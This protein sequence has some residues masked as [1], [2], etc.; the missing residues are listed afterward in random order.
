MFRNRPSI[1]LDIHL[2]FN[3]FDQVCEHL[4]SRGYH[5]AFEV[6]P[7]MQ[8][9]CRALQQAEEARAKAQPLVLAQVDAE[10]DAPEAEAPHSILQWFKWSGTRR[11]MKKF[12]SHR[13]HLDEELGVDHIFIKQEDAPPAPS[14]TS[15]TQLFV[16]DSHVIPSSLPISSWAPS[17]R[18]SDHRP[19]AASVV[20]ATTK[21][22]AVESAPDSRVAKL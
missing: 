20:L 4:R 17:F 9:D 14:S 16:A 7:P 1:Y 10:A 6:C 15:T 11:A 19:I 5:S 2:S 21:P 3:L 22:V 12:V 18:I 8:D 13:T